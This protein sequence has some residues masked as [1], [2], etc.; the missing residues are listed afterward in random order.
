MY[1]LVFLSWGNGGLGGRRGKRRLY[2][3][4]GRGD[5]MNATEGRWWEVGGMGDDAL[6]DQSTGRNMLTTPITGDRDRH[7][8][9]D[10]RGHRGSSR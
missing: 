4:R 9:E 1:L 7:H 3:E 10:R 6:I 8:R 2:E 5:A